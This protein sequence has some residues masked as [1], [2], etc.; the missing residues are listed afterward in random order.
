M[1]LRRIAIATFASLA[2]LVVIPG[3][4]R[5]GDDPAR[6]L[7]AATGDL[8]AAPSGPVLLGASGDVRIAVQGSLVAT[9]P[10]DV[11]PVTSEIETGPAATARLGFTDGAKLEIEQSTRAKLE[12]PLT[13]R[14]A[15]GTVR[16]NSAVPQATMEIRTPQASV[17]FRAQTGYV[18]ASEAEDVV[19]CVRCA[20]RE[21]E[22]CEANDF[23]VHDLAHCVALGDAA[24]AIVTREHG[25]RA[26]AAGEAAMVRRVL[27]QL[28]A[29]IA[30]A[31]D[32]K[33]WWE[34]ARGEGLTIS[35]SQI[36]A[37]AG[38]AVAL[39]VE[40][41][42]ENAGNVW[43]M[44]VDSRVATVEAA[45]PRGTCTIRVHDRGRGAVVI[46]DQLGRYAVVPVE[47]SRIA[48]R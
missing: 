27:E 46:Y 42:A 38:E 17:V 47:V 31:S 12:S 28:G 34:S 45:D 25:I 8:R 3:S 32:G 40:R 6:A 39:T 15:S 36:V 10:G 11:L 22:Q 2:C 33:P 19:T 9:K 13:L 20:R 35:R 16:L 18:T 30:A 48:A 4:M 1:R 29:G 41:R 23:F 37:K 7:A 21:R 43:A 14:L 44:S 5:A 24:V 26:T